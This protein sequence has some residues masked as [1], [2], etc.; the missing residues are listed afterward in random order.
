VKLRLPPRQSRGVSRGTL[1]L[2]STQGGVV[3]T[4]TYTCSPSSKGTELTLHA[5][6]SA[7][8]PIVVLMPIIRFMM[9]RVDGSQPEAL[10]RLVE[11]DPA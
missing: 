9:K 7:T 6:C 2:E 3:A 1:V 4:Y 11:A 10:K 8:G 5:V